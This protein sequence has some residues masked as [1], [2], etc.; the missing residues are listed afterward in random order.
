MCQHGYYLLLLSVKPNLG[1]YSSNV[2]KMWVQFRCYFKVVASKNQQLSQCL[3]LLFV[4][5]D[6]VQSCE[7]REAEF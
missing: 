4:N 5:G 3:I 2:F 1:K 7:F 6:T